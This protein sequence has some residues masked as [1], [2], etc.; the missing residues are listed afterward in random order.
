MKHLVCERADKHMKPEDRGEQ[1]LLPDFRNC[2][3]FKLT[4]KA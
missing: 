1:D 2:K 4:F 3:K